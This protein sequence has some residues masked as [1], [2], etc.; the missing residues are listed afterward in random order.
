MFINRIFLVLLCLFFLH[1]LIGKSK[2]FAA[3]ANSR[4]GGSICRWG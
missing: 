1:A 2:G 3:V 4:I